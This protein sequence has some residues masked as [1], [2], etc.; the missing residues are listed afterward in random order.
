MPEKSLTPDEKLATGIQPLG[1]GR[2]RPEDGE[3]PS[4]H[5]GEDDSRMNPRR[6]SACSISAAARVGQRGCWLGWSARGRDGLGQ[7]GWSRRA[8]KMIREAR[9]RLQR[10]DNVL[11]VWGSA[12]ADS[13]GRKFFSTSLSFESF[14]YYADQTARLWNC[15]A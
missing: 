8:E 10:F 15:S 13:L 5:Y 12:T 9:A 7:V 6:A 3:S 2:R 14:Y 4:R 1:R 11:Y